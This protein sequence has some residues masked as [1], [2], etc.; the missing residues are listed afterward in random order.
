MKSCGRSLWKV[1]EVLLSHKRQNNV[2]TGVVPVVGVSEEKDKLLK[3]VMKERCALMEEQY[4]KHLTQ[5][6]VS[7]QGGGMPAPLHVR[8]ATVDVATGASAMSHAV[9]PQADSVVKITSDGDVDCQMS[10]GDVCKTLGL[11]GD[12]IGQSVGV[13]STNV[14]L[15]TGL[16]LFATSVKILSS[17]PPEATISVEGEIIKD[18]VN[19]KVIKKHTVAVDDLVPLDAKESTAKPSPLQFGL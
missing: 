15:G 1:A 18:G 12:G 4:A 16:S 3:K 19:H 9:S 10:A 14:L 6:G 7:F 17:N 5:A 11:Q 13:R 2:P 8:K